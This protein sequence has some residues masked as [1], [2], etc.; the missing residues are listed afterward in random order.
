M[1]YL[2]IKCPYESFEVM[3]SMY[4]L[5]K[6]PCALVVH[7]T[8]GWTDKKCASLILIRFNGLPVYIALLSVIN[9]TG[10]GTCYLNKFI[11]ISSDHFNQEFYNNKLYIKLQYGCTFQDI[12]DKLRLK[13]Q[14]HDSCP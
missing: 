12:T 4:I 6:N 5:A 7:N 14:S 9:C 8:L 10:P 2:P 13:G 11:T 3:Y 1:S